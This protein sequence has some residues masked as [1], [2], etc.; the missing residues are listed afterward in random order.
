MIRALLMVALVSSGSSF[1]VK[2]CVPPIAILPKD[3]AVNVPLNAIPRAVFAQQGRFEAPLIVKVIDGEQ[4]DVAFSLVFDGRLTDFVLNEKLEPLTEYRIIST[5][6]V[7]SFTTGTD[8]DVTAP[9]LS[10]VE[11]TGRW[12]LKFATAPEPSSIVLLRHEGVI[13]GAADSA[14]P[15]LGLRSCGFSNFG[16][17]ALDKFD[18]EVQLMDVAGNVSN[19]I[20]VAD[21]EGA[22][23][24]CSSAPTGA[25]VL[26]AMA[27][28]R[29]RR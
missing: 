6:E 3:G 4:V 27:F 5:A 12:Q 14:D 20:V 9:V 15:M 16:P 29:R 18:L 2:R 11:V 13:I 26:L 22:P 25:L 8:E 17:P 24:G 10:E 23:R 7:Q 1:A 21:V 28:L 19:S